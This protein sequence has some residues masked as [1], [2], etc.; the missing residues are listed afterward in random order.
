MKH[1]LHSRV[2]H[3]AAAAAATLLSVWLAAPAP[4]FGAIEPLEMHRGLPD[5]DSRGAGVAPS[6][7][8]LSMVSSLGA[9]A[10]WNIFGTPASLIRPGGYLATGLSTDPATAARGWIRANKSL[11]K[12]SDQGVDDLE[13]L[14]VS[15]MA[16]S[17]GKAVLFRQRW[18]GLPA[19]QDGMISVGYTSGKIA[20]V[21]SSAAGDAP[22]PGGATLTPQNAWIFAAN[23]VGRPTSTSAISGVRQDG[24]WTRFQVAGFS[25]EQMVR[26]MA[27][28]TPG[29]VRP[30]YLAM[31]VDV[32][33]GR[34]QAY[35]VH[36]DAQTG[37][38]L[39]RQ[40][41]V[42]H[43][44][45][46]A[47]APTTTFFSG[48]YQDAPDPAVCAPRHTFSV[49][50]GTQA[51]TVAAT[52]A[53]ITNDL[54][55]DL[56]YPSGSNTVVAHADT[57]TSPEAIQYSPGGGVA[58]GNYDVKICPYSPPT[59]PPNPPYN[60][61][62]TFT[63][64]DVASTATFPYPPRWQ[65]FPD[66]PRPDLASDDIREV[67]C[68]E[69]KVS[70]ID[71]PGCDRGVRNLAARAPWDHDVRLNAPTF[72]TTGNA[73]DSSEA[74][75]APP[76]P[77]VCGTTAICSITPAELYHPVSQDREYTFPWTNS[78]QRNRCSQISFS[79]NRNDVDAA[80]ANLFAMHNR[81][82]DWSY[83][84]GFTEQNFNLQMNNFGNTPPG[85]YPAGREN[86]PEIGTAQTGAIAGGAPAFAG[87]N[88][89]LQLT[90]QFD[91]L[92]G[93]TAMY[94]WQPIAGAVY[95]PC[96]D[97]DYDMT[98]IGHEYTHAISNRMVGGPDQG[99]TGAQGSMLGESWSDLNAVEILSEYGFAPVQD[100]NPF[101]V[102]A[103][104]TG[105]KEIG[106]RNWGMNFSPVNYGNVG[107]DLAGS[108]SGHSDSEIWSATNFDIRQALVAKYNGSFPATNAALQ[109]KCAEGVEPPEHCPGNRRWAQLQH[110]SF[111][112][113]QS[114]VSFLDARDAVLAADV[115]RFGGANQKELWLAFAR[116][117]MG[118][119]ASTN[120]NADLDP[121][122]AFDLPAGAPH[123][124]NATIRF[125]VVSMDETV[126]CGGCNDER[127]R[128]PLASKI[129]VGRYEAR[130]TPI[131]QTIADHTHTPAAIKF[132]PGTYEFLV[133]T[134]GYGHFRFQRT[135]SAG[136]NATLIPW[137]PKNHASKT[138]GAVASGDG[139]QPNLPNLI[140]DTEATN[141][142][143][144]GAV[145]PTTG[146][147][148]TVRLAGGPK[149]VRRVQ[150]SAYLRPADANDPGG[151]TGGQNRFTALRQFEIYTCTESPTNPGCA[152]PIGFTKIY[153]SPLDAF[154]GPRFRPSSPHLN[155]RS[156][157][158]PATSAT[159]VRL[160]VVT[161]QC[162]GGPY[163][164]TEADLAHDSDCVTG[165]A[166]DD[167][168]RAAELQV[169]SNGGGVGVPGDPVVTLSMSAP[170]TARAGA[171]VD[172]TISYLNLG[173]QP[174]AN[175]RITDV[176]PADL[177]FV[178]ASNGGTYDAGTRKVTWNLGT[179]PVTFS[180][181]VRL[182]ARIASALP[183]GSVV[184]NQAEFTGDLTVSPP[185]AVSATVILP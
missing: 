29:G 148:A 69:M 149:T 174:S 18:G 104:V 37:Q 169:F 134:P 77:V 114:A 27:F 98:V 96:V 15:P 101:A 60:Y 1:T 39:F 184:T 178:S 122:P 8:Q 19:G 121:I 97:G 21:S 66:S 113:M 157:D 45:E 12:L 183:P 88:N 86:D 72:T 124:A 56:I 142:A 177:L 84:L 153:T 180:G 100:E 182:T 164:D 74:W 93:L 159:H 46:Q 123:A 155:I 36:V 40:N 140:D 28:P 150:V 103:Y 170:A 33:E 32:G 132:A 7:G 11:F 75:L 51:I 118:V 68:W 48:T 117:G 125:K 179:V 172:Y 64:Q 106:I 102:G 144:R 175:A 163:T 138:H 61:V 131:V 25:D 17:S 63:T 80:I 89:A 130:S 78:W 62:G 147:Q 128:K 161:N 49:P 47:Q 90:L 57:G 85:P 34:V 145:P 59:V 43:I 152:N 81:M 73:A 70:G 110:D 41:N 82:H 2:R 71:V 120:T 135:F 107:Y 79:D 168:V 115:M 151:D 95:P 54:F 13:L 141:W 83:F 112:L 30:A 143:K 52:A 185:T 55:I 44:V 91:G 136:Q 176:L 127:G 108:P 167:T 35:T 116:R 87:R 119:S 109:L 105:M 181:S 22:P 92:P 94:L 137:V 67:W 111:L 76:V 6:G 154:P 38:V 126:P 3:L 10:Q 23:D 24:E 53:V 133:V 173:P 165:S 9:R 20:Y 139:D 42:Q 99:I 160:R 158:V 58:P 26:L 4:L 5:Y 65:V 166:Q 146:T 162:I 16:K 129:Y 50:A 31:V 14:S 156:F 171:S